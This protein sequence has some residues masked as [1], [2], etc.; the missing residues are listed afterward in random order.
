MISHA[1]VIPN[2]P[3]WVGFNSLISDN[4]DPK[5]IIS[6][7][8]PINS[9]PTN[10]SVV[11]ETMKQSQQICQDLQQSSIQVTYDLAIAKVALQIQATEKPAFDNLFIHL[12]P[13]HIMMAY[14]KALGKVIIDCG[15]PNVMVQSN[16]LAMG[17]LNGFLEGK[18]FNRCKRLH[19]L[20][21]MGLEILHYKSFLEKKNIVFTDLMVQ[22]VTRLGTCPISS[23]KIQN[24]EL[25]EL[26]NDYNIYKE[27]TLNG[28]LGKTAQFYLIY[29][30]LVNYYLTLSRSIRIG[31]FELFRFIL[32]KITN[33][34]FICNQQN[35]ARW[36]VKYH[37]NLLNVA[38]THP[39]LFE[40][41]QKG[42]FGIKRTN[43]H[44]S[45]QPID[46]VL[47]QTINADAARRLTGIYIEK[48]TFLIY[49]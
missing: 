26:L 11:L 9:S 3:M 8:T 39:D 14:F 34:F 44:F 40:E 19:P 35:Y 15:L 23:F 24:E 27:Q 41:F 29:V 4:D 42:C 48:N 1:L 16:M 46:L 32:P 36:G 7:L 31:D 20:M 5:Q 10:K 37:A 25:D 13:F 22:E 21:A 2:V 38:T 47:E 33:L 28:E 12:G 43:K 49:S 45:R 17:S 6:Y 30:N 18:H